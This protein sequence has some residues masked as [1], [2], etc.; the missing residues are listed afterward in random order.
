M[1]KLLNTLFVTTEGAYIH[2]ERETVVVEINREKV[3]QLPMLSLANIF[4]FGR[5][6][7]SPPFMASCGESGVGLAFFTE[8]GRF[9]ARVQGRQTGNVLL[10]R[11]QYRWA[12]SIEKS[13]E[14]AKYTVAAKIVNS[15]TVLQRTIRNTPDCEGWEEIEKT[16]QEMKGTLTRL[17][18]TAELESV[19]GREGEAANAYFGI[20]SRLITQQKED[21]CFN[22]RNRR[23]PTDPVNALL[24]FTYAVML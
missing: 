17:K 5:I 20:F 16:I 13:A 4:C 24:S 12:D 3:L 2:K 23:P 8:Y 22:G 11:E 14:I 21:F 15:R 1:K 6:N 19:R 18:A 9:Q 10:R 7:V